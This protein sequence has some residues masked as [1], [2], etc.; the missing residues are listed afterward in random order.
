MLVTF[1]ILGKKKRLNLLLFEMLGYRYHCSYHT[2]LSLTDFFHGVPLTASPPRL[3]TVE[4]L[5]ETAKGVTNMALAHEIVVNGD[6]RINAVEL[7]EGRCV[8]GRV[9]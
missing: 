8:R 4:E 5:L 6:F 1:R 9:Y 2:G 3:V 7:A